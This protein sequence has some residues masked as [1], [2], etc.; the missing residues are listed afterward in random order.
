MSAKSVSNPLRWG[1][2]G[3]LTLSASAAV[4]L[5]PAHGAPKKAVARAEA[6]IMIKEEGSFAAGGK[7]IGD[8]S[9]SIHCDQG[10]VEYQIPVNPRKV[11]L[12]MWHSSSAHVWQNRWDGGEGYQS[13]FLRRGF[14]VFIWDGPRVGRGNMSC[15]PTTY[16]PRMGQDQGNWIAWRFG[17]KPGEWFPGVQ[18]P[19]KSKEAYDAAMYARY[20]EYDFAKNA[21]MEAEAAAKAMD[22]I[23]PVVALTNSAGGWRAML[24]ALKSDNLKGIVAYETAAFVFPEGEGPQGVEGG[25][26]PTHVP[27]AEFKRLTKIPIQL[28]W[29]DYTAQTYWKTNVEISKQFVATINKYGGHAELLMLPDAGLKGNTHIAFADMNNVQVADLLSAFLKKNKLDLR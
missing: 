19:T 7:I 13:I 29:G 24:A 14:P 8:D 22:K 27:L 5:A 4:Y 1:L 21:H 23:G 28:V 26:G 11:G 2:L 20:H 18:F 6:P 12:F 25:F 17:P 15:E 3:A 16:E 10:H 9:K